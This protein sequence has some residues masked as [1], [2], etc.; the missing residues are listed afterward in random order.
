[1]IAVHS[2]GHLGGVVNLGDFGILDEDAMKSA[3]AHMEAKVHARAQAQAETF[4]GEF[5]ATAMKVLTEIQQKRGTLDPEILGRVSYDDYLTI[6]YYEKGLALYRQKVA[7]YNLPGFQ[8]ALQSVAGIPVPVVT[9]NYFYTG[10]NVGRLL[11]FS[12][13]ISGSRLGSALIVDCSRTFSAKDPELVSEIIMEVK[14]E[15]FS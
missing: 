12:E 5:R 2:T 3:A 15:L 11:G 9:V 13:K 10:R 14:N 6:R 4:K 1:M 7:A 8:D